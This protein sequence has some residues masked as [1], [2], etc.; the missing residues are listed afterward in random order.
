MITSA[1][2]TDTRVAA[3]LVGAATAASALFGLI[4]AVETGFRDNDWAAAAGLGAAYW[5]IAMIIGVT[6]S[7]VIGLPLYYFLRA[8][9]QPRRRWAVVI[10]AGLAWLYPAL[11]RIAG[12]L[13]DVENK[14]DLWTLAPFDGLLLIV[15]GFGGAVFWWLLTG[16]LAPR[17]PTL[18]G[19]PG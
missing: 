10:G 11:M 13:S 1:P 9:M 5:L 6:I 4:A 8:R 18:S 3:S 12:L 16:S 2:P 17:R 14:S 15:G 19:T 7:L